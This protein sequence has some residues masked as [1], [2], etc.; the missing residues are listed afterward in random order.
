ML[1]LNQS[2]LLG[3]VDQDGSNLSQVMRSL[4][5]LVKHCYSRCFVIIHNIS[6]LIQTRRPVVHQ[7]YKWD[8]F[9]KTRTG[10]QQHWCSI[11]PAI[12]HS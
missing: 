6:L 11:K 2:I 8:I 7:I 9:E 10:L 12:Q 3:F 1:T 5:W 4:K